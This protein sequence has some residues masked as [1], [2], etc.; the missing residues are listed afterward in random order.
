MRPQV[1]QSWNQVNR[2]PW[3]PSYFTVI[4]RSILVF[5]VPVIHM[6]SVI[7]LGSL[8]QKLCSLA[9]VAV[10]PLWIGQIYSFIAVTSRLSALGQACFFWCYI[11]PQMVIKG[12][13]NW[14]FNTAN[15]AM[16][17][18]KSLSALNEHSCG[19]YWTRA[20]I[21][22]FLVVHVPLLWV[23]KLRHEQQLQYILL[24]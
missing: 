2:K 15:L 7:K 4:L 14:H 18:K 24:P 5:C 16:L 17:R 3:M 23:L 20:D 9:F 12:F 22:L 8:S 21:L 19:T 1:C 13:L 10:F 11:H 6:P